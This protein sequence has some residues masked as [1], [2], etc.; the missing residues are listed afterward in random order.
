MRL[1]TH[2]N[3]DRQQ[4]FLQVVI[5][6]LIFVSFIHEGRVDSAVLLSEFFLELLE[7]D[8]NVQD[9]LHLVIEFVAGP[10]VNILNSLFLGGEVDFLQFFG[11]DVGQEFGFKLVVNSF[12]GFKIIA[13]EAA[14][15][16][17]NSFLENG[18]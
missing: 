13:F 3:L 9:S 7:D 14:E 6:F 8:E 4:V 18:I 10:L 11:E 12:E 17:K 15:H 2:N 1:P 16:N 5:K